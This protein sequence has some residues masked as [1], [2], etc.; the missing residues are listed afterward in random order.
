MFRYF[1][2]QLIDW[3]LEGAC[4][5]SAFGP[6]ADGRYLATL[7]GSDPRAA[8]YALRLPELTAEA[9]REWVA[10]MAEGEVIADEN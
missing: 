7:D 10:A 1:L 4:N 3:P 6:G 8:H 2:H 9:A 5:E